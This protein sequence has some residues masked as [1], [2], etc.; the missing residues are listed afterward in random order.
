MKKYIAT[1]LALLTVLCCFTACQKNEDNGSS[2]DIKVIDFATTK[3]HK[4]TTTVKSDKNV[5][6]K[7]PGVLVESQAGGNLQQYAATYGYKITK[8]P[9]GTMS[10]NMDGITYSLM[11]SGIGMEVMMSLGEIVDGN[12]YPYAVRLQ[13]YSDDFSYILMKVDSDIYKK[14]KSNSY[15]DLAFMIGQFGLYYQYF[16]IDKDNKC[17]VILA[18]SKTGEVV[19][20]KVYTE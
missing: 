7:V 6:I 8:E 2:G 20:S 16:T 5:T 9:D 3:E 12:D 13:D 1:A 17:E 4:E 11:L 18:D 19:Y 14:D 10:M 15:E